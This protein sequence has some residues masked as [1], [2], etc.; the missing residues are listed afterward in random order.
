MKP[1]GAFREGDDYIVKWDMLALALHF[2]R[3][4]ETDSSI[5]ALLTPMTWPERKRILAPMMVNLFTKADRDR[6]AASIIE[7]VESESD[8]RNETK[9]R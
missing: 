4:R 1:S 8:D 9:K 5:R 7:R 3:V 6:M 2:T